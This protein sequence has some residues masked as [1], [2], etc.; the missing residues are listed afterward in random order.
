[1]TVSCNSRNRWG[2]RIALDV[3][4]A[5][6]AFNPGRLGRIGT[7]QRAKIQL[8]RGLDIEANDHDL[9]VCGRRASRSRLWGGR[10]SCIG[11]PV[12]WSWTRA[13]VVGSLRSPALLAHT[14]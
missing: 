4:G 2:T 3:H 12:Y 9:L 13:K 5:A 11:R 6:K 7:G 10:C 1:M 8:A 14:I